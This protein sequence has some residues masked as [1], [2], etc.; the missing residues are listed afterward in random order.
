MTTIRTKPYRD[1]QVDG[2]PVLSALWLAML[3]LEAIRSEIEKRAPGAAR[4]V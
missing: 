2:K 3:L 1:S 4:N